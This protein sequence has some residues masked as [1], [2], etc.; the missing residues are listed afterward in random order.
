MERHYRH[1]DSGVE[2]MMEE[3]AQ[4]GGDV[5]LIDDFAKERQTGLQLIPTAQMA[6]LDRA[7]R[8]RSGS[9]ARR[10]RLACR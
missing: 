6:D 5:R 8:S 7:P 3:L 10:R 4:Q 2:R 1:P 9:P